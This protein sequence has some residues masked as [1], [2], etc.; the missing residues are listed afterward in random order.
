[1]INLKK[2]CIASAITLLSLASISSL[3]AAQQLS[4]EQADKL[5]S[6]KE[7]SI[8]GA[9]YTNTDYVQ[10]M[11]KAAD[12]EGAPY[13]YITSKDQIASNE[14]VSIV[15]ARLYKA[16]APEKKEEAE[17]LLQYAGVYQYPKNKAIRLEPYDV[18]RLRGYYPTEYELNLAIGKNAAKRGA[19]AYYVDRQAEINGGSTEITA[20]LF[21][22]DAAERLIQPENAIPYDSEAGQLALAQGGEAAMQV[23]RPGYFSPS[24]FNEQFYTNKYPNEVIDETKQTSKTANTG[25]KTSTNKT[26][27]ANADVQQARTASSVLPIVKN[28]RYTVTLPDGTQIQELNDATAA[29]MVPFDTIKFR[30]YYVTEAE[31]SYQAA[32]RTHEKG[33]KFYHIARIAEDA[34]GPNRTIYIDI[35]R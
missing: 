35:Y 13:F 8:R 10:A 21:K 25:T 29:K 7:I 1:M 27:V 20:Y 34:S 5:E 2:T 14:S 11:S 24:A 32:K 31:I 23:E 12:R 30:G 15:H 17:K 6:F 18:I 19:Y 3:Y 9:F 26:E 4:P 22:E 16:D 28:S 33:G